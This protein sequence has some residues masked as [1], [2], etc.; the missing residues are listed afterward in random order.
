MSSA[1]EKTKN[2]KRLDID[3]TLLDPNPDNPNRMNDAEFNLLYDNLEKTGLT[4]PILVRDTGDG[5]YRVVGG[6]HRLEVAKLHGFEE[7]PCTIIDDPDF[8][9][10]AEAFQVVRMN[11]IRGK[12]DPAAFLKMYENLAPKYS[13]EILQESF[14]F[15]EEK[16]FKKMI[17]STLKSL[18]PDMQA[19]FKKASEEIKT[20]DDLSKVLNGLFT[21]YGSSLD[22]GYM[23]I[24]FGGKDSIWLRM[25]EKTKK[26]LYVMGDRC[27]EHS[28]TMDSLLGQVVQLV[29]A[30]EAEDLIQKAI[31]NTQPVAM[32]EELEALPTE[33]YLEHLTK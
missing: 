21:K 6:H 28:R 16:E 14:G 12:M 26:A 9:A 33:D 22:Y 18:P 30:G 31:K 13:D 25:S 1:V 5:R 17:A 32:P 15:A 2:L 7:V 8:D 4:D 24:D 20:I 11:M 23:L 3:V 27:R 29:A 10:D 19:E